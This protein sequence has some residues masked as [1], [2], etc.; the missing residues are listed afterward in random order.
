MSVL[1]VHEVPGHILGTASTL[2]VLIRILLFGLMYLHDESPVMLAMN[3]QSLELGSVEH[4]ALCV[5]HPPN[6]PAL[7]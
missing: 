6:V 3:F 7:G 5:E 1:E 4:I 2:V